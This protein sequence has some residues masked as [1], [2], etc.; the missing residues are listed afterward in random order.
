MPDLK[1]P[2]HVRGFGRIYGYEVKVHPRVKD[3]KPR[4]VVVV[5][6]HDIDTRRDDYRRIC[7]KL[8]KAA[9]HRHETVLRCPLRG[10]DA[11]TMALQTFRAFVGGL[12]AAAAP[13]AGRRRSR[14][15][16]PYRV[17]VGQRRQATA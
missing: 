3:G 16:R 17:A 6:N 10:H 14:P 12:T 1:P 13:G 5:I 4:S 9:H 2:I 11:V 7:G 15:P 8:G